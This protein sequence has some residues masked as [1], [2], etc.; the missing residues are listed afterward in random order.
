MQRIQQ[1]E[2]GILIWR[3]AVAEVRPE[4]AVDGGGQGIQAH[5][6]SLRR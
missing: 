1:I 2:E 6:P 5:W 3:Y 4:E